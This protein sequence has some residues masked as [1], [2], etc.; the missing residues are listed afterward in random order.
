MEHDSLEILKEEIRISKGKEGDRNPMA[1]ASILAIEPEL[2]KAI[3]SLEEFK[4]S[5][6]YK[7]RILKALDYFEGIAKK[8]DK[9]VADKG[10]KAFS[11]RSEKEWY[12]DCKADLKHL[13]EEAKRLKL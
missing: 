2:R 3:K 8:W 13:K 11:D 7:D 5:P 12:K 9:E 1:M 6:I 4:R 10:D